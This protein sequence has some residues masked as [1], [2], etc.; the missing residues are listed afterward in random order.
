MPNPLLAP[1]RPSI[2]GVLRRFAALVAA[3]TVLGLATG[4]VVGAASSP[5]ATAEARLRITVLPAAI[6]PIT[7]GHGEPFPA[8][9][10]QQVHLLQSPAVL[11]DTALRLQTLDHSRITG[12]ELQHA[13]RVR[14]T[15]VTVVDGQPRATAIISVT[16]PKAYAAR[17][18]AN[19]V[20]VS[21]Q[22]AVRYLIRHVVTI[23]DQSIVGRIDGD[24]TQL[25]DLTTTTTTTT[26]PPPPAGFTTAPPTTAAGGGGH[27]GTTTTLPFVFPQPVPTAPTTTTTVPPTTTT[28]VGRLP[29]PTSAT[30]HRAVASSW[31]AAPA[32]TTARLVALVASGTTTTTAPAPSAPSFTTSGG[33][34]AAERTKLDKNILKNTVYRAK[35]YANARVDLQYRFVVVPARATTTTVTGRPLA[36]DLI[37]GGVIGLLVGLLAAYALALAR[38]RFERPSDPE[39]LYDAPLL[40]R[41]PAFSPPFA[42]GIGSA[43]T[44]ADRA[45][46]AAEAVRAVAATV[47]QLKDRDQG[48]V[49]G[50][51]AAS[52]N[53]GSSTV[54][55]NVAL[56]LC[57][58][59]QQVLVV[60]A[61]PTRSDVSRLLGLDG[62]APVPGLADVLAGTP[63][64]EAVRVS[65]VD[66]RLAVVSCGPADQLELRR[67]RSNE[68]RAVFDEAAR[69]FDL[70]LVDAPPVATTSYAMDVV[71]ATPNT[72]LI[73]PR[74]DF[75]DPHF[76]VSE[77]LAAAGVHLVGYVCNEASRRRGH[78]RPAPVAAPEDDVSASAPQA[79][80]TQTG[81]A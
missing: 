71:A 69:S 63:L 14:T 75:V 54:T 44:R 81:G 74:H 64:R 37:A 56:A 1:F 10:A 66:S 23:A 22:V 50:I 79:H 18:A 49:T 73:V 11:A 70:V 19:L 21:Y 53:A 39:L 46:G 25:G 2:R 13:V 16:L 17:D 77:R 45:G 33:P 41:L 32:P 67:W 40:A 4:A 36:R 20:A 38:R 42:P 27:H 35:L 12:A 68:L 65:T 57:E 9:V 52:P 55:A 51:T 58:R 7:T 28:T 30:S 31:D 59:G 24:K 15:P 26:L 29:R 34:T 48:R 78:A 72:V 61:E 8:Y 47:Q 3:T 62:A 80:L 76:D 60:D 5:R 6:S 43:A